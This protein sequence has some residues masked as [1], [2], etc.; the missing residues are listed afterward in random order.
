[1]SSFWVGR[2]KWE[3]RH[4]SIDKV[5]MVWDNEGIIVTNDNWLKKGIET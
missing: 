3:N 1:M 5:V 4:K 2:G